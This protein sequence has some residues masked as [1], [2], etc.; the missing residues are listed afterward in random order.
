MAKRFLMTQLW[1]V[2]QSYALL[3]LI[4]WGVVISLTAYPITSAF[5][6]R[7]FGFDP[8]TPGFVI[9][10]LASVFLAVF[11][12]LY[13]F[14]VVYD[15]YLKLWREQLDVTLERNPY[16]NE[17]LMIKEI[18]MWR[19]MLLPTLR[20]AASPASKEE[21]EIE[22][23]EKWIEKSVASDENIRKALAATEAWIQSGRSS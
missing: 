19:H 5:L 1:R 18:L 16:A 9:G 7:Q 22:F 4:I 21:K 13:S 2:Q 3:S 10:T 20:A 6:Q 15:K 23:M 8:S 11:L 14:G 12:L 17:K